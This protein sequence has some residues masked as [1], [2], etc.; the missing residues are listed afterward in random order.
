MP[1]HPFLGYE[2]VSQYIYTCLIQSPPTS[3][4]EIMKTLMENGYSQRKAIML[5]RNNVRRFFEA[6][7][8]LAS[9]EQR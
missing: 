4:D 7:R 1:Y 2:S 3:R 8:R 6:R 9:E 5:Y